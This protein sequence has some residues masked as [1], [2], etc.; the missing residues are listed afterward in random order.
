M[1]RLIWAVLLSLGCGAAHAATD[2]V[3]STPTSPPAQKPTL[4]AFAE[5][6]FIEQAEISP[7]GRRMAGLLGIGGA[8]RVAILHIF[9]R[10]E[11]S[12]SIAIP[13]GTQASWVRW[14]NDD[15]IIIGLTALVPLDTDKA[16]VSRAIA[17]NRQTGKL[18]KLLWDMNGQNAAD[19]IW[20]PTDGSSQILIAAQSTIYTNLEGF[21]PAVF[22]VDVTTGH[23]KSVV[24]SHNDVLGWAA[25]SSGTVRAG[26]GYVDATRTSRLIYR[27]TGKDGFITVDRANLRQRETLTE[28][29]LFLPG[30]H[31]LVMHDDEKG[32]TNIY[33]VDLTTQK[34]VKTVY[35]PKPGK[36][37]ASVILSSDSS[38]LLGVRTSDATSG[39]DWLDPKLA[40]LQAQ[41]D[42][43]VPDATVNIE[44]FSNDRSKMLVRVA[45]ADMPGR[46]YYYD[47]ADGRLQRIAAINEKLGGKHLSPVKLVHYKARDGLDIEAI[48]TLPAGR[49]PK[50]LPFIVMPHGGPWAQDTLRYDYWAQFLANSGYAVLQP[51][52][53]GS[54]GYGTDFTRKG[55]GQMGLAMQDDVTD[56]AKWAV[57]QGIADEKRMCIVGASYGGYAAMWGII[58]DPDQYRCAI[59]ISGVASLRREV[60]D[61]G[62]Y[63]HGGLY[64]DQWQRMTPDFAAVSPIKAIDR[65]KVPLMLIHG[66]K[67]VTVDH[68]Q[69]SSMY[70]AMLKA[71]KKVEFVSIP[72]ADHYF[73][74]QADRVTLLTS[75]ESFL[76]R[77]NPA[78]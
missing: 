31:A 11:K 56:S 13:D 7:D 77:N 70:A 14:I 9:D 4:A 8:Q 53:R 29:F 67:D 35:A 49:D 5:L 69:S 3:T 26:F 44:S 20:T 6:P 19:I 40:E 12:A 64:K 57:S 2:A 65:I 58:K 48:L 59:S 73:T 61:F 33:E 28:P 45:A 55:E 21:W 47:I 43:A 24:S 76:A 51:N 63:L 41:F 17:V 15:N 32:I 71:G 50:K 18:T 66:K 38:T 72:L 1:F 62:S 39:V 37:V 16:Y 46:L 68:G 54:T 36:D 10:T 22:R 27:R 60:N 34:E 74:R 23:K 75:I 52:F 30:D 25:D 78:Y 42:K